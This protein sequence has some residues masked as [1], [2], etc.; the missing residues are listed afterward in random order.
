MDGPRGSVTEVVS[1]RFSSVICDCEILSIVV[2]IQACDRE[3]EEK[4]LTSAGSGPCRSDL[5]DQGKPTSW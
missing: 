1:R 3:C 4:E 2:Q 5:D